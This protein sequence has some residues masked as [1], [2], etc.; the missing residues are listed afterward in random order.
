M[1]IKSK[2]IYK[3][4]YAITGDD[5][6]VIVYAPLSGIITE[7]DPDDVRIL[8]SVLSGDIPAPVEYEE[9][10]SLLTSNHD[11]LS[12]AIKHPRQYRK[13]SI[14]SNYK[15]N[16]SCVYC[17]S[18]KGR[19]DKEISPLRMSSAINYLIDGAS[20][21]E[22]LSLFLS[23]G[24]E[25]LLSW[26]IIM[27]V[28]ANA[29]DKARNKGVILQIHFMSNG[30]VYTPEIADFLKDNH[31]SLCISFEILKDLQ[32]SI[33]GNYERVKNNIHRYLDNGNTLYI[34]S[35]ITPASVECLPDMMSEVGTE[36]PGIGTVT[37][38]PVTGTELFG[39]PSEMASFYETFDKN[40]AVAWEIARQFNIDLNTSTKNITE[41]F[42]ERYCPGKLCLTPNGTF[43]IC[44]CASSPIEERYDKCNYGFIDE[45]G[46]VHFD[47]DK[48]DKLISINH[49]YYDECAGCFAKVHCGGECMTRRDTY[50]EEY[51]K[52][53]CNRTRRLVLSE[54]MAELNNG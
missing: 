42:V 47:L 4:V 37:M 31:I 43:T 54:L 41:H 18:A 40:F 3:N 36:Y 5:L 21:G 28:L 44:H 49:S 22:S 27:P 8:Q 39:S 45:K 23:G 48:F 33:R 1:V 13:L 52:V 12:R 38:E 11:A 16:L 9:I 34:S 7:C 17:Y 19:S 20:E 6:P 14:L 2:E 32:G 51:M 46:V 30:T 50:S 10:V 24:G 25:P 26:K 29:I 53:V 35:T 15:C